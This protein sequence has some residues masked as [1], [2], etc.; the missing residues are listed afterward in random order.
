MSTSCE[1]TLHVRG[2]RMCMYQYDVGF[3]KNGKILANGLLECDNRHV[4]LCALAYRTGLLHAPYGW[5]VCS[6]ISAIRDSCFG[7][8]IRIV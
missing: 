4:S 2:Y 1:H 7:D 5:L 8:A 3:F 6:S